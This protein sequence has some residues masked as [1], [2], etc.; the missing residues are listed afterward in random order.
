V[1]TRYDDLRPLY[2]RRPFDSAVARP[3][4]PAGRG[5]GG[6]VAGAGVRRPHVAAL[7]GS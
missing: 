1:R 3:G 2:G 6:A 7:S 4:A 5:A